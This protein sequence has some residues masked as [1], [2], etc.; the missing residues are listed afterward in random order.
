LARGELI[1][2][3]NLNH[4]SNKGDFKIMKL[5]RYQAPDSAPWS[6]L[7]RWS[8]LRDELNSFFDT[9]LWSGFGRTGQLF[10]GWS[11][12]LD[13]Y[14]S[15]DNLVAVV[16]LPGMRKEDIDIS[17]HD[18]TLTISGERK[19][20]SNDNGET[21]QR[22]ERYVGTFRR[23]ITLPTRVDASKVSATYQDGILKVALPKAEEA[24][25]KQ[26]QVS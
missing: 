7:D 11:P 21:A 26:I 19:R 2:S 17:L 1:E 24:K 13:L 8:N 10:T 9:P 4:Q 5:I 23:S 22:T 18:G 12:A 16:E 15:G 6:A 3:L 25:P 14:E 20:E